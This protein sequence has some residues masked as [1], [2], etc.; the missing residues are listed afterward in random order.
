MV[1]GSVTSCCCKVGC[2]TRF[3]QAKSARKRKLYTTC[4]TQL[5]LEIA[6]IKLDQFSSQAH[7]VLLQQQAKTDQPRHGQ[8]ALE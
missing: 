3:L 1:S 7:A 4:S 5:I 2:A 8:N 6:E